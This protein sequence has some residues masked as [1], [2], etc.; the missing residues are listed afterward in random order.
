MSWF[1]AAGRNSPKLIS[2]MGRRPKRAAPIAAPTIADS[3]IGASR[4][5]SGP[6]SS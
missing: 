2:T 6:N 3:E 1:I 5:R 4:I